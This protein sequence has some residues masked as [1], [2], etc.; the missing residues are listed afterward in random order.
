[1]SCHAS[2]AV[3]PAAPSPRAAPA[4]AARPVAFEV[5]LE[6]FDGPFDLLLRLIAQRRLDVTEI[7]LAQVTDEFIAHV[8][9]AGPGWDLGQATDFL[10]VAATLLELKA[11][12]LLPA[13]DVE[14]DED[15]AL[16]EARDL[17]FARLLQYGA[18]KRAAAFLAARF[19]EEA[20]RHPRVVSLEPGLVPALPELRMDLTPL[21]LA[22]LAA[23]LL[24]VASTPTV[25]VAHLH[26]P[27]VS[28][29]EQLALLRER[30]SR[31]GAGSFRSLTTDCR[32]VLE[33]VARFLALLELYA[34]G[35]VAFEQA[36]PFGELHVR[37]TTGQVAASGD[38]SPSPASGPVAAN[39]PDRAAAS[40]LAGG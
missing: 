38:V 34:A 3:S 1:M 6:G 4:A 12:R 30:L 14:D 37:W 19:T 11:A 2:G 20:R 23:G 32:G 22:A 31:R 35:A 28:V 40:A 29:S 26:S 8:R 27:T 15:I 25:A 16:L 24:E 13:A 17:L 21:D 9:A 7:S 33:V 5:H 10:V 36:A 39:R 18:Y